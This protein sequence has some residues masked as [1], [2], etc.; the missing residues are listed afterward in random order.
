MAFNGHGIYLENGKQVTQPGT[1]YDRMLAGNFG[2]MP[3]QT[4]P[5]GFRIPDLASAVQNAGPSVSGRLPVNSSFFP[6]GGLPH[7]PTPMSP[8]SDAERQALAAL[9]SGQFG[10][11][12]QMYGGFGGGGGFGGADAGGGSGAGG[13]DAGGGGGF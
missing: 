7:S 6:Q 1:H 5:P 4:A 12:W 13:G 9:M 3:N 8:L 10:N 11:A 2:P